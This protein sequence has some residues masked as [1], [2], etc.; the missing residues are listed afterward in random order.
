MQFAVSGEWA[1][2][3]SAAAP[4]G[5]AG[6][7]SFTSAAATIGLLGG[8]LLMWWNGSCVGLPASR[9]LGVQGSFRSRSGAEGACRA[10]GASHSGCVH[11]ICHQVC[12][13]PSPTLLFAPCSR[14]RASEEASP[15]K[16]SSLPHDVLEAPRLQRQQQQQP[17]Q[18]A[19]NLLSS[20]RPSSGQ[21]KSV[22]PHAAQ[23]RLAAQ[24]PALP[25]IATCLLSL[26]CGAFPVIRGQRRRR[27]GGHLL[28]QVLCFEILAQP[29]L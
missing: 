14:S 7:M 19:S 24:R 1:R 22:S 4:A 21:P 3:R 25:C 23:R 2:L 20:P 16:N 27:R 26:R 8:S 6:A 18:D 29:L 11:A 17:M 15:S 9:R 5:A 12:L 28:A 13:P 10:T